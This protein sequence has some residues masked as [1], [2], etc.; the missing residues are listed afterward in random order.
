MKSNNRREILHLLLYVFAIFGFATVIYNG[1]LPVLSDKI[2]TTAFAQQDP[3]LNQRIN[4]IE[5]RFYT[6]ETRINRIEQDSKLST[7]TKGITGNNDAEIR[8]LNSQVDALQ[9]RL[10][11]AECGLARLDERTLT[12]AARQARRKARGVETDRCRLNADV[13]LQLSAR[14]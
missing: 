5:Q 9:L 14:P 11:E 12:T 3:F 4:Q 1:L 7:I 2:V 13:P 8:A 6:I 10:A